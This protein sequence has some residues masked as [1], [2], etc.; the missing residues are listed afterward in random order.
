MAVSKVSSAKF[1][2]VEFPRDSRRQQKQDGAR[3]VCSALSIF[4]KQ[5]GAMLDGNQSL[6]AT[7]ESISRVSSE[8]LGTLPVFRKFGNREKRKMG[9]VERGGSFAWLG[10]KRTE[11][12]RNSKLQFATQR[13]QIADREMTE[14]HKRTRGP[15]LQLEGNSLETRR[16]RFPADLHSPDVW[17]R[18]D[19]QGERDVAQAEAKTVEKEAQ[20]TNNKALNK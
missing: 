12:E 16:L 10:K 18:V 17:K 6:R 1:P 14:L 7:P 11:S 8:F 5:R 20:K 3:Q 13:V 2:S 4:E 9:T 19:V 15:G